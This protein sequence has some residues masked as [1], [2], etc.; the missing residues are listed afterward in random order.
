MLYHNGRRLRNKKSGD[1][2]PNRLMTTLHNHWNSKILM[3]VR[4]YECK[5][6]LPSSL[7]FVDA[8]HPST[9]IKLFPNPSML[10]TRSCGGLTAASSPHSP[11]PDTATLEVNP[12]WPPLAG[13]SYPPFRPLVRKCSAGRQESDP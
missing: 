12:P 10:I 3:Q 11:V 6:S 9:S 7:L 5:I 2:M 4:A 8:F 1:C 13:T